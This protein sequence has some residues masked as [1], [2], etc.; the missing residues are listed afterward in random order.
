MEKS[1]KGSSRD[2]EDASRKELNILG[3]VRKEGPESL[4]VVE[5]DVTDIVEML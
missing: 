3:G 4:S 2:D 1:S 5:R